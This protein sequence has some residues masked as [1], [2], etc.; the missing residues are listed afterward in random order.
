MFVFVDTIKFYLRTIQILIIKEIQRILGLI[1]TTDIHSTRV[2]I[3]IS[4]SS[5]AI[6]YMRRR[7]CS[8]P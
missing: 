3:K 7:A 1:K 5:K 6:N 2:K 8:P 4:V